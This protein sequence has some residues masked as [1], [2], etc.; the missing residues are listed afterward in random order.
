MATTLELQEKRNN[1]IALARELVD[2]ADKEGRALT[3][4]EEER[5]KKFWEDPKEGIHALKADIERRQELEAEELR[6]QESELDPLN[7]G[8]TESRGDAHDRETADEKRYADAFRK[9]LMRGKDGLQKAE[10]RALQADADEAGGFTVAPQQFVSQLIKF[11]DDQVHVRQRATKFR[12]DRA[13]NLGAPSLDA[14]PADADWTSELGTGN[15]DSTMDFGKR[16]LNPHPLAK[17]LKVSKKLIRVSS[18]NIEVLVRERL[19]YKFAVTQEKAFLT[20]TGSQQPLGVFT[21]SND[22]I[23]TSRDVSTG[24][25]T[26]SMKFDGLKTAKYSLKQQYRNKP[27]TAW[28]FHRDGVAQVAKLK[29][30]EGRYIWAESVRVGEPDRLM[31]I[32]VLESEYAPNTFTTGL[33]V[34]LLGDWSQY[35]IADAMDFQLQVLMELYAET[36]QVGYIGRLESDGMP[37]LEEAFARVTL[38]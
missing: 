13:A 34:G 14:D 30:G 10:Y 20:G 18:L 25:T 19:G 8:E 17:R 24:N 5:Y 32:P 37:V 26:T 27:S 1:Q 23:S 29:D 15:E 9:Y 36:N 31:N 21:A 35:W 28:M 3:S 16:E 7:Q 38:A 11:V 12:V 2:R 22:G 33:Y 6:M 4:E